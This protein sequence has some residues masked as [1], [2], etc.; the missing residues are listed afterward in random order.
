MKRQSLFFILLVSSIICLYGQ[1]ELTGPVTKEAILQKCAD[2]QPIAAAY[3]PKPEYIERLRGLTR[4]VRIEI[5]LGA[6][7]SDSKAHVSEYFK[8]LEMA[9]TPLIQTSYIAVPEDKTK[10]AA[11]YQGK[12]IQKIPT[13][14]IFIDGLEKGRIIEVPTK[15]VEEDLVEII[16]R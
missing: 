7:C 15:S 8:I 16:E 11:F 6:W 2:W 9:D 13:F 1:A 12:D 3:N 4:E 10:R 14:I 5:F